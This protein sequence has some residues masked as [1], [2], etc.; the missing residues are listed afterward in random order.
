MTPAPNVSD[1]AAA[2]AETAAANANTMSTAA[3]T[4]AGTIAYGTLIEAANVA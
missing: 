1:T 4:V 3:A 2:D